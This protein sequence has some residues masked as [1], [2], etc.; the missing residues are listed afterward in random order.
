ML[1][2]LAMTLLEAMSVAAMKDSLVMELTVQV[3]MYVVL[4]QFSD[5]TSNAI[6][7]M[8]FEGRGSSVH[9]LDIIYYTV[10]K[11]LEQLPE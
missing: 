1:M 3:C 5:S 8:P 9:T 11:S 10:Q 6:V 4:G 7:R 2:L